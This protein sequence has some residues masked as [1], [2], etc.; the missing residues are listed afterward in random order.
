MNS[1]HMLPVVDG[2][3]QVHAEGYLRRDIKPS[4]VYVPR[5]DESP[6]LLDFGAA[7]HALGRQSRRLTAVVAAGYSPPEQYHSGGKQG[8]WT[9][10]YSLSALCYRAITGERPVDALPRQSWLL[11]GQ[12]GPV[13]E[14]G[15]AG[16]DARVLEVLA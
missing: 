13:A 14:L 12:A 11:R 10:V 1:L 9:D 6:V 7:R 3:K 4:N 16:S 2:L 8:P 5:A 15:R